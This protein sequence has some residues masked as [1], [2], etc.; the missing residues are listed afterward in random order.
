MAEL[1]LLV[2][3]H[4]NDEYQLRNY[5]HRLLDFDERCPLSVVSIYINLS[6]IYRLLYHHIIL[7][8]L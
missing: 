5:L 2:F 3:L 1:Y 6:N 7:F 4:L 8:Y